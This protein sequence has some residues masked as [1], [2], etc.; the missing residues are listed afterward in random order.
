[1]KLLIKQALIADKHSSF[2]G[3]QKDILIEHGSITDIADKIQCET[4]EVIDQKSLIISP[5]WVDIFTHFNDPGFEYKETLESGANAAASGGF[6]TVFVIPNT[7]P[8]ISNKAQVEYVVQKTRTLPVQIIPLGAVTKNAEGKE[9]AEMYDMRQSGAIAF[10][11]GWNPIQTPGILLKALQYVKSFNGVII[12]VPV[13]DSIAKHGL[14]HEGISSTRLGLPGVPSISEELMVARDI[15]LAKYTAS[16]V[17]FCSVSTA[18]S[19]ELITKAKADGVSVTCSVTPYHLFFSDE[20]LYDYDTNLKVNPPLRTKADV[21][22]L[23]KAVETGLVDCISS[24]HLPQDWDNKTC[25][26]EYAKHGMIGLETCYSVI[27]TIF[28]KMPV[29]DLIALL[30]SNAKHI[31]NLQPTTIDRGEAADLTLFDREVSY[32]FK[33]EHIKSKSANTA[34]L[35][36]ALTGKVIGTIHKDRVYLNK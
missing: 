26:F 27:N 15:E 3:L 2:N 21:T 6:T 1:M 35:D 29:D 31:F 19:I 23:R 13:D 34:F 22:A 10:T 12:Q 17:H 14:M 33:K 30:S 24:H 32:T 7:Q 11:D 28:P 9:L 5:G 25:E 18:R 36:A 16:R 4:D 20:D 8:V